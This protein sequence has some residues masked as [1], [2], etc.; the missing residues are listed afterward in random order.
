MSDALLV[1][2]IIVMAISA[3]HADYGHG[4]RFGYL[5][6]MMDQQIEDGTL[7]DYKKEN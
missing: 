5:K 1:L 2:L 6:G 7:M 3:W 4:K